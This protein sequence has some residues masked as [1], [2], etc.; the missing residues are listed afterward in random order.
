MSSSVGMGIEREILY[1]LVVSYIC[2]DQV[3]I[4]ESGVGLTSQDSR[5]NR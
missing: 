2:D 5:Q 4:Y 1:K 3:T